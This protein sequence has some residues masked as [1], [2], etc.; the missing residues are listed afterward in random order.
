[1]ILNSETIYL[2]GAI[3]GDGHIRD[4][5]KSKK[6]KSIDYKIG[7]EITDLEY[8]EKELLTIFKIITNTKSKVR[9]RKKKDRKIT[10]ILE[11]RNKDLFLFYTQEIGAHKGKRPRELDIPQKIKNTPLESKNHFIAGYFDT[12][13]GFRNDSLGL[14]SKCRLFRDFF[15]EIL[16]K[17]KIEFSKDS[18]INKK[19]QQRY[20]G[21]R[22][23]KNS[24]DRFLNTFKLRNKE[25]LA[26]INARYHAR[27]PERS[28]G[29]EE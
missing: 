7:F 24:I 19:Y 8:L 4:G 27:V 22:I 2:L 12:D 21:V 6:D 23:K 15:C 17:N 14:S 5:T 9:I 29:L 1:M 20:Y 18:W 25:K 16:A 28:N 11:I 26:R 10:G 13:G 3:Y